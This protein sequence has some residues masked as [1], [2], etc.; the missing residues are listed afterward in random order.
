[1]QAG[2]EEQVEARAQGRGQDLLVVAQ[3]Q[4]SP[5][6]ELQGVKSHSISKPLMG[7]HK[8]RRALTHGP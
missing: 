2:A 4:E 7:R 8:K 6:L 5:L 3:G 1:M